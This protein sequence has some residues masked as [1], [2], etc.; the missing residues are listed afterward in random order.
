MECDEAH[1]ENITTADFW[2]VGASGRRYRRE[3]VLP[4]L[5]RRKQIQTVD[6]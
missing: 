6:L 3:D 5:E 1:F 2:E 4:E